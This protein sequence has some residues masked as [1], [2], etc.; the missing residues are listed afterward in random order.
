MNDSRDIVDRLTDFRVWEVNGTAVHPKVC[1]DAAAEILRLRAGW[2]PKEEPKDIGSLNLGLG[3]CLI[4]VRMPPIGSFAGKMEEYFY[5]SQVDQ[6]IGQFRTF[7][8]TITLTQL[9]ISRK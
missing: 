7:K 1:E 3:D 6:G 9:I 5:V 4:F 8:R 2:H